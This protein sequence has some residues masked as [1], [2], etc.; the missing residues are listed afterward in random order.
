MN[1]LPGPPPSSIGEGAERGACF[2][3][4]AAPC[5]D[6]SEI[7][8]PTHRYP[9]LAHGALIREGEGADQDDAQSEAD[10][11]PQAQEPGV[12]EGVEEAGL[13]AAADFL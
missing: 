3:C 6:R 9:V 10:F 4:T 8:A 11:L 12:V 7:A 13:S 5:S 2:A 1:P